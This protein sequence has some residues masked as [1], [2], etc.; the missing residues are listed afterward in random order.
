VLPPT[1]NVGEKSSK[2]NVTS[3]PDDWNPGS[4]FKI[5]KTPKR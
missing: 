1:K 2:I 4:W 5:V 3:M